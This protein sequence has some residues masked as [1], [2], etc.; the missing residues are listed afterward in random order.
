[1]LTDYGQRNPDMGKAAIEAVTNIKAQ[2]SANKGYENVPV[3]AIPMIGMNDT[4]RETFTLANANE[5]VDTANKTP[6]IKS[7]RFWSMA[8]DKTGRKGVTACDGSGIDQTPYEF[9]KIFGKFA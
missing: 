5:L 7:L 4:E 8:R 3:G 6:W 1:M 9:S 2:V